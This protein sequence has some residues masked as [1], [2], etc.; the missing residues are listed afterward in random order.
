MRGDVLMNCPNCDQEMK[1]GFITAYRMPIFW[2]PEG[3]IGL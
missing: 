1:N 2:I 3:N